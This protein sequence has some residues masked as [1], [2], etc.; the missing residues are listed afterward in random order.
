ME[1]RIGF[2]KLWANYVKNTP[3][4]KWSRQQ[5]LLINSVMKS[6]SQDA[7]LYLRVKKL[8]TR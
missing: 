7:K 8:V 5:N 3:N 4:S 6:A 1:E 2:I